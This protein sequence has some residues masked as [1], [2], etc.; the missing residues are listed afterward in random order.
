MLAV[1]EALGA[2]VAEE[3]WAKAKQFGRM[4]IPR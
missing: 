3:C 4:H 1:K 2:R